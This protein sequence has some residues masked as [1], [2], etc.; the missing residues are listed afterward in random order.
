MHY[1]HRRDAINATGVLAAVFLLAGCGSADRAQ[2][3][4]GGP[5]RIIP[6]E[7]AF[8]LERRFELADD[9][10]DPIAQPAAVALWGDRLIVVDQMQG[11]VKVFDQDGGRSHVIGR[12]GD[13]PGEFRIPMAAVPLDDGR[14]AVYDQRH[15]RVEFFGRDGSHVNGWEVPALGERGFGSMGGDRFLITAREF[16]DRSEGGSTPRTEAIHVIDSNGRHVRSFGHVQLADDPHARTFS[17]ITAASMD[18]Y[19]VYGDRTSNRVHI[20]DT[21][22]SREISREVGASIYEPPAWPEKKLGDLT[23][24]S[25]W[26]NQQM[27]LTRIVPLGSSLLA[28]AFTGYDR[29]NDTRDFRYTV[30]TTAGTVLFSTP[31]TTRS[32]RFADAERIYATVTD[33]NGSV[34]VEVYRLNPTG[35]VR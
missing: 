25:E 28:V 6:F 34:F 16:I 20:Y 23:A 29:L 26:S 19:V 14:L 9:P 22:T 10:A 35:G 2:T 18:P 4:D 8:S 11:N 13:G 17:G 30:M 32:L 27:W 7:R 3:T 31:P 12:P 1:A 5:E 21:R 33:E 15:H 24:V